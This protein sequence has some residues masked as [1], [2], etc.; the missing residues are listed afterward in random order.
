MTQCRMQASWSHQD[1]VESWK[2]PPVPLSPGA[3]FCFPKWVFSEVAK[4]KSTPAAPLAGRQ[5]AGG[6]A[7]PTTSQRVF[8]GRGWSSVRCARAS[9]HPGGE[10]L[11]GRA[12]SAAPDLSTFRAGLKRQGPAMRGLVGLG[13]GGSGP[14]PVERRAGLGST[15]AALFA[16]MHQD[17][18]GLG[19]R[20]FDAWAVPAW[21]IHHGGRVCR[22]ADLVGA[23][24]T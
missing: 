18:I 11:P 10:A 13:L 24:S 1:S 15:L 20:G 2:R 4:I 12:G 22:L 21:E 19:L 9:V 3:F 17:G 23:R 8:W 7:P 5:A 14:G 6:R 16:L